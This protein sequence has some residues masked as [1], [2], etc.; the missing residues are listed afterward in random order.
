MAKKTRRISNKLPTRKSV[1]TAPRHAVRIGRNERCPCD[2]GKKYKDCHLSEG[3]EFLSKLA[4]E[5]DR[6][7]LKER[8]QQLKEEGVPWHKRI[9]VR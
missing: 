7:R 4:Q 9:F 6:K 8:R 5:E 3:A 2:S 1:V